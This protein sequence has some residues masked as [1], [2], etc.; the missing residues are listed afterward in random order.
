MDLRPKGE[1]SSFTIALAFTNYVDEPVTMLD[2]KYRIDCLT[3]GRTIRD[4]TSVLPSAE[5]EI[6]VTPSDCAIQNE[7]NKREQ[8]QLSIAANDDSDTQFVDPDPVRWWVVNT[9]PGRSIVP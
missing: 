2:V 1:G 9:L 3:T 8:R 4:W 6:I 5:I 7:R